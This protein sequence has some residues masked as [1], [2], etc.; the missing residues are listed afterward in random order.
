VVFRAEPLFDYGVDAQAEVVAD[1][2]LVTGRLLGLQIKGGDSYLGRP[3]GD[4]GWVFP[5]SNDHLA[6][7]LGH[8]LPIILGLVNPERQA[9]WQVITSRTIKENKKGSRS[10][11][12]AASRLTG[13]PGRPC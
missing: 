4:E 12:R 1:D 2:A 6:Y 13:L 7:W 8:S 10:W 9:F 5:A 3:K 11:F